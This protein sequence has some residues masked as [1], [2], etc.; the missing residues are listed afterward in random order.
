MMQE[1][2]HC[3]VDRHQAQKNH[4]NMDRLVLRLADNLFIHL[5]FLIHAENKQISKK[6]KGQEESFSGIVNTLVKQ[7]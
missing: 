6:S 1:V 2:G 3:L 4:L 5:A 7:D